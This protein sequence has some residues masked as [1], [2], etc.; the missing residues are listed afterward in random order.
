[1]AGG[2]RPPIPLVRYDGRQEFPTKT[3]SKAS[4]PGSAP[5]SAS[6]RPTLPRPGEQSAA[7][8]ARRRLRQPRELPRARAP[9]RPAGG[10][11]ACSRAA[12]AP[13]ERAAL[14]GR[15]QEI[16]DPEEASLDAR[17][18]Q[19]AQARARARRARDE[20]EA[21]R[22]QPASPTSRSARRRSPS[23]SAPSPQLEQEVAVAPPRGRDR[24]GRKS[25]ELSPSARRFRR[26]PNAVSP[27]ASAGRGARRAGEGARGARKAAL[28]ASSSWLTGARRARGRARPA[29]APS[30][31][32][33]R[34]RRRADATSPSS[35][36]E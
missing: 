19:L 5:S 6:A 35:E 17:E 2:A 34:T 22:G 26:R 25:A 33:S 13:E 11:A 28:G 30:S 24:V 12:R 36:V 15:A 8:E 29:R 16:V 21:A 23:V 4:A 9:G 32:G 20:I 14:D 3:S 7:P 27:T 31:S 1:M 10:I 18:A